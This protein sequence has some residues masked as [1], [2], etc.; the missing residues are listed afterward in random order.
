MTLIKNILLKAMKQFRE[1]WVPSPPQFGCAAYKPEEGE[2]T[3]TIILSR[4]FPF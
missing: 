3:L 4:A 1:N 2:E